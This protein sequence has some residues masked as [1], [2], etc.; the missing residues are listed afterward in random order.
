SV[1]P[2]Y[3]VRIG[4]LDADKLP[5]ANADLGLLMARALDKIAFLPFGLLVDK[6]RWQ[7][8][9]G[10]V[11][12]A[13]YN[14]AWWELRRRYQGVTAPVPR[15]EQA[16]D[17]GAKFHIP[18]NTPYMR[19]FLA[20]ILQFQFHEAACRQ[21]GWQGPLHRCSIYGNRDVGA[22]FKAMLEM[23]ASRPWPEALAAFTG[24]RAID[25]HAI[26]AYFAPLMAWLVEQNKGR[27]CGW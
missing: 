13:R 27:Q 21:A 24:A 23:G 3:L 11:P 9:S 25:A 6:W 19:Y 15:A 17:P 14:D 12:P 10:A 18:G 16:F 20:H 1:T 8:F 2:E 7:V 22:R 4:L 5:G 26:G